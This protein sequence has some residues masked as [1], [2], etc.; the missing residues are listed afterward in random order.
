VIVPAV[1]PKEIVVPSSSTSMIYLKSIVVGVLAVLGAAV[2]VVGIFTLLAHML[3]GDVR[4]GV[5]LNWKVGLTAVLIFALGFAWQFR[6]ATR[7]TRGPDA[8]KKATSS[9]STRRG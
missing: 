5:N 9:A 4:A 2:A 7:L 6:Q 8:D 3:G 1:S